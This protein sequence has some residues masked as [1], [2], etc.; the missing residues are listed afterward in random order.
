MTRSDFLVQWFLKTSTILN[1]GEEGLSFLF[2]KE[3]FLEY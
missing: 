2:S 3:F 1:L